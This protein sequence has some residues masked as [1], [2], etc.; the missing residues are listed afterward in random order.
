MAQT[1]DSAADRKVLFDNE[2]LALRTFNLVLFDPNVQKSRRVDFDR[3]QDNLED[4]LGADFAESAERVALRTQLI[5]R[6]LDP[7][8]GTGPKILQFF[9]VNPNIAAL[10][11]RR[12]C[13]VLTENT[14]EE[15]ESL[16]VPLFFLNVDEVWN[17]AHGD[18]FATEVVEEDAYAG[19]SKARKRTK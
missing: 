18:G 3:A 19:A 17:L 14:G 4:I 15:G 6:P 10:V 13:G 8:V 1:F 5:R 9:A 2:P 16:E 11:E 7:V 12:M